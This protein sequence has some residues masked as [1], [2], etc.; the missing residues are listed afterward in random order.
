M[1]DCKGGPLC[2]RAMGSH[3]HSSCSWPLHPASR[4]SQKAST[5][6][7][8]IDGQ[9]TCFKI[10]T[11]MSGGKTL[12][13]TRRPTAS[14][15]TQNQTRPAGPALTINNTLPQGVG[16][17]TKLWR[18]IGP[19]GRHQLAA[20]PCIQGRPAAATRLAQCHGPCTDNTRNMCAGAQPVP[21]NAPALQRTEVQ[22]LHTQTAPRF[23]SC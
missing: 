8:S 3:R 4:K 15:R 16:S 14:N 19:I 13:R 22:S 7:L 12:T 9:V 17:E 2:A 23:T 21:R 6:D 1:V 10:A 5:G 20:H 11:P 18:P